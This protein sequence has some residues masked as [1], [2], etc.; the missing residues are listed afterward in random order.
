MVPTSLSHVEEL[1]ENPQAIILL[2]FMVIAALKVVGEKI[3][4]TKQ[5]DKNQSLVDLYDESRQQ[6]LER[7]RSEP[8]PEESAPGPISAFFSV[9]P[10]FAAV[11]TK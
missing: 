1:F 8:S 2:V 5:E 9:I 11:H 6:I 3:K 10:A 4:G 7:Q